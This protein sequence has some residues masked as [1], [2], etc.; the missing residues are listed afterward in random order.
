MRRRSQRS[1]NVIAPVG[2]CDR[3][4][5]NQAAPGYGFGLPITRELAELY[6]GSLA[7]AAAPTVGLRVAL[8]LPIA[9]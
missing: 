1:D 6:G 5:V 8:T 4:G 7:L 9:I 2:M 3:D